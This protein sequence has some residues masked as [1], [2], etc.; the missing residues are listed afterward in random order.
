GNA[1]TGG[2]G[3]RGAANGMGKGGALFIC[4]SNLCGTGLEAVAIWWGKTS[5]T[6]NTASDAGGEQPLP[7]RD[8]SD[9]C[10]YLS[11]PV[12]AQLSV[13]APTTISPGEAF[14]LT[15]TALDAGGN[16]VQT[17]TGVVHLT[18]SDRDANLPADGAL[19]GGVGTFSVTLNSIGTQSV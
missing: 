9:V 17:Y 7:G 1:A 18:S 2:A 16:L 8:D 12:A 15:V 6:G 19:S 3:G 10:G 13:L 11:S 5:F 4:S 14:P